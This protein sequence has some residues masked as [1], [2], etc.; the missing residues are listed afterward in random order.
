MPQA[1]EKF[2]ISLSVKRYRAVDFDSIWPI[3][4]LKTQRTWK[5]GLNTNNGKH[6][7]MSTLGTFICVSA[8]DL[9]QFHHHRLS[10]KLFCR[11]V[12][13]QK[14]FKYILLISLVY[15][16][17]ALEDSSEH[18]GDD[19][20]QAWERHSTFSIVLRWN[21]SQMRSFTKTFLEQILCSL[22][23]M[24]MNVSCCLFAAQTC[25][26]GHTGWIYRLVILSKAASST[27]TGSKEDLDEGSWWTRMHSDGLE[28][29]PMKRFG[30]NGNQMKRQKATATKQMKNK[31][32]NNENNGEI[33]DKMGNW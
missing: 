27:L 28:W 9:S 16:L 15:W 11:G 1:S 31:W 5:T 17:F 23:R 6:C 4:N 20:L 19:G 26:V 22:H 29:T 25:Q 2:G 21:V 24:L 14:I 13:V 33:M 8:V 7:S 18:A 32:K 30:M 10:P 12:F 3:G